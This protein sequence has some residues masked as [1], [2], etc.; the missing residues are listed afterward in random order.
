MHV[1]K[2]NG[3]TETVISK[4][5][6]RCFLFRI[7]SPA[8]A[9]T[10]IAAHRKTYWDASHNC[11]AYVTGEAQGSSDD[12]EPSGTAG[13]PM[14]SVLNGH[15]LTDVLAI[16]TRYFGGTKLGAGG[17]VRAY[18][19]SVS[20]ALDHIGTATLVTLTRL[21]I[22]TDYR[23]GPV[24]ESALRDQGINVLNVTWGQAV[25][26]DVA[27]DDADSLTAWVADQS[28]GSA[29]CDVTGTHRAEISS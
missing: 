24:I 28:A 16:V 12:G 2:H 19:Q 5:R 22:T 15:D 21:S 10:L 11:T 29:R 14:L 7:D 26:L 4:S 6:F 13:A 25:T 23:H 3:H 20:A 1:I 27:T 18:G 8:H 17:L 9:R